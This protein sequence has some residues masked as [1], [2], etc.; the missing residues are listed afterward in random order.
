M[1]ADR[2]AT[3]AAALGGGVDAWGVVNGVRLHWVTAGDASGPL[4]VLL[5]GF[6]DFWYGWRHQLPALAAAG[7]RVVAV[8]LR[9][10]NLSERPP[11]V[12][13]YSRDALADD[14]AALV[15]HLGAERAAIVGHDWGGLIAWHLAARHPGRVA[16]LVVLNAPHPARYKELLRNTSQALRSWY[17]AFFQIPRGCGEFRTITPSVMSG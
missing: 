10:Y 7:F 16:R 4:V 6:P 2:A 15:A 11:R 17:A 14:V 13:D 3:S 12:E 9:G 5:H 8:D 1:T